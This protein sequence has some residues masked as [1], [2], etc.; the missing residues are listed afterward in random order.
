[1][2]IHG[3]LRR[4][5]GALCVLLVVLSAGCAGKKGQT[6]E[7]RTTSRDKTGKGAAIG[8]GAGA[9]LGALIGEREADEILAGAAIGAGIGAGVGAYMDKQEEKLARIP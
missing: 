9:V 2:L 5:T 6:Q 1:M 3:S 4:L 8:A 7:P